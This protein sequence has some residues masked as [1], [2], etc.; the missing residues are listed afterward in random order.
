[1]TQFLLNAIIHIFFSNK[2]PGKIL[3]GILANQGRISEQ[4]NRHYITLP[5]SSLL[6][7]P[8]CVIIVQA[9]HILTRGD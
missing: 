9:L 6:A 7:P 8:W 2:L 5:L 4:R 3:A 1:M